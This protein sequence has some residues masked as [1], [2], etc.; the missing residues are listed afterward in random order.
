MEKEIQIGFR[1]EEQEENEENED[2]DANRR[3]KGR[4]LSST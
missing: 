4:E 1:G 2:E 3:A